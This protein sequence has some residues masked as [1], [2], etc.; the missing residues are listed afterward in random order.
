MA[1]EY[2][3]DNDDPSSRYAYATDSMYGVLEAD[4]DVQQD[5]MEQVDE[6]GREYFKDIGKKQGEPM[7]K[8]KRQGRG[9]KGTR[10]ADKN[11]RAQEHAGQEDEWV[12]RVC[13]TTPRGW[14]RTGRRQLKHQN[15]RL[16][17]KRR[18]RRRRRAARL[19]R[20][21]IRGGASTEGGKVCYVVSHD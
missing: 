15:R 14:R 6:G 17:E 11:R 21:P 18:R 19:R 4:D 10:K 20:S 5:E 3:D 16:R 13:V 1:F 2:L 8:E 9:K 7:K 12:P